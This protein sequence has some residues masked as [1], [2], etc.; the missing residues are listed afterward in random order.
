[1]RFSH[2]PFGFSKI[3]SDHWIKPIEFYLEPG[4]NSWNMCL[5]EY[6]KVSVSWYYRSH[7]ENQYFE[8]F[9]QTVLVLKNR[10]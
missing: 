6:G 1:L 4:W 9:T 2:K 7:N 3:E 8:I 5:D 10:K